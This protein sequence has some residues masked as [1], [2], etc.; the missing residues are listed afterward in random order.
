M[1]KSAL[2]HHGVAVLQAED[3][4]D[5]L[6]VNT[7]ISVATESGKPAVVV[8]DDTDVLSLLV[9]Q[10]GRTP[11][12]LFQ[13]SQ[14]GKKEPKI[15]DISAIRKELGEAA[16]LILFAHAISGTDTTSALYMK[17]KRDPLKKLMKNDNLR[18]LAQVFY[19]TL[20]S[21]AEVAAA[22]EAFIL[23]WY[24]ISAPNLDKARY[25]AYVR[26]IAKKSVASK[27]DLALLPPTSAAAIQ[28][29]LRVYHQVQAWLGRELPAVDWGW[30]LSPTGLLVPVTTTLL[31]APSKVLESIA[32]ACR[33][34]CSNR[35][36]GCVRAGDRCSPMCANC[37][38]QACSNAMLDVPGGTDLG[39]YAEQESDPDD[40]DETEMM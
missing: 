14:A 24:G 30:K 5:C 25:K 34:D 8:S 21:K 10:A 11:A 20:S 28:H 12:N 31:A 22:G 37:C 13:L 32:C 26:K 29:C 33:G 40:P 7:A 39:D 2:Q 38:G 1:V 4:A 18:K 17:G 19:N 16:D 9:N 3:D 35:I 6:I 36:C 15:Y 27:I 23:T